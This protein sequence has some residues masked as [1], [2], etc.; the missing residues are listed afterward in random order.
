[1]LSM[2]LLWMPSLIQSFGTL[3]PGLDH[4][5]FMS[6]TNSTYGCTHRFFSEYLHSYS[7]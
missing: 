2:W 6:D 4:D 7:T 5:V 1:M 3:L